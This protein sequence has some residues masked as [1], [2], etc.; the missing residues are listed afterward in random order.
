MN[1]RDIYHGQNHPVVLAVVFGR[2]CVCR[3]LLRVHTSTY[4]RISVL[5]PYVLSAFVVRC[6]RAEKS[7]SPLVYSRSNEADSLCEHDQSC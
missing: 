1:S 5:E 4:G 6:R 7:A 2:T 3:K